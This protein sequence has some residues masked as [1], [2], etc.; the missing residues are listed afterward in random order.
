MEKLRI[1][2]VRYIL[3]STV[4]AYLQFPIG[5]RVLQRCAWI[6]DVVLNCIIIILGC[7]VI[8]A[9]HVHLT[10]SNSLCDNNKSPGKPKCCE[11]T[12]IQGVI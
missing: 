2:F 12:L 5:S 11:L 3:K 8:K 4:L 6:E 1:L 9:H 7:D 10:T